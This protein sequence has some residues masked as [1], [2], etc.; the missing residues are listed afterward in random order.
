MAEPL[1][2]LKGKRWMWDWRPDTLFIF[3]DQMI[4]QNRG[5][6]ARTESTIPYGQIAQVNLHKGLMRSTLELVNTGG[7]RN[8]SVGNLA[9][10]DA[11][12]AKELIEQKIRE[13]AR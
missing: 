5:L 13:S 10:R 9:N 8:V 12:N 4:F 1:M 7:A 6:V 2:V 11:V 3:E